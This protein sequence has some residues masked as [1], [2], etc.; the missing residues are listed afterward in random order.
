[1]SETLKMVLIFLAGSVVGSL[2]SIGV[3]CLCIVAKQADEDMERIFEK[4]RE[5][6]KEM[7]KEG[8]V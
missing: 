4:R 8:E 1:M 6:A 5:Y 2:I 3:M 7:R